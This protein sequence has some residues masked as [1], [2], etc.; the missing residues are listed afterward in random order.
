MKSR[1]FG[2]VFVCLSLSS[3]NVTAAIIDNFTYTTDTTTGLD[4]LDLTATAHM[5][6]NDVSAQLGVGGALEGWSYATRAQISDFWDAF[7]GDSTYYNGWS[8]QNNGLFDVIAPLWGDVWCHF[9]TCDPG[10]GFSYAI[11]ADVYDTG[12]HWSSIMQDDE[13]RKSKAI[14]NDFF[15]LTYTTVDDINPGTGKGSAL[16]RT[17]AVPLPGVVWLFGS[18]MFGLVV[19]T[20]QRAQS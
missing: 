17:S 7:G 20:K 8:T 4:W 11:T 9:Q 15:V 18:G 10:S 5:S 3:F 2:T 13:K 12:L 6:Y 19:M 16:I 14:T 1:L